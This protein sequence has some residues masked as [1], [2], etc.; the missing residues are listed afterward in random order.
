MSMTAMGSSAPARIRPSLPRIHSSTGSAPISRRQLEAWRLV[1][2][3]RLPAAGE[4][5]VGHEVLVRVERLLAAGGLDALRGAVR[6][7]APALL[8]VLEVGN[9]DLVQDLLV[10][11][12][13]PD[14]Y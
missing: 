8:I 14:R 9:H 1:V 10:H 11:R 5:R 6:Q 7:D 12:R 2:R 4:A 13:V 3:E